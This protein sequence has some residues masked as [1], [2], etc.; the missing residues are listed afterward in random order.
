MQ[1]NHTQYVLPP[2]VYNREA[3]LAKKL[4]IQQIRTY[5]AIKGCT[6]T[7][8]ESFLQQH[9]PKEE[10]ILTKFTRVNCE[11]KHV[12]QVPLSQHF[13]DIKEHKH[14]T[15]P[16]LTSYLN[17]DTRLSF[18]SGL[19]L[20]RLAWRTDV[21]QLAFDAATK[22]DEIL[23]EY[24]DL[25]QVAIKTGNNSISGV[26]G[27]DS[28]PVGN[29][30]NHSTLTSTARVSTNTANVAV[31]RLFTGDL[32]LLHPDSALH[33]VL[34]LL[35]EYARNTQAIHNAISTGNLYCPTAEEVA[36]YFI[37]IS[38][39]Y[40]VSAS[41]ER[42]LKNLL[43][44]L[45]P[46]Q[47]AFIMYA[48]NLWN[49][50]VYNEHFIRSFILKLR[51][52]GDTLHPFTKDTAI[53]YIKKTHDAVITAA[54]HVLIEE[55]HG[56]G[57]NYY[58]MDESLV[59]HIASVCYNAHVVLAEY[60]AVIEPLIMC[61]TLPPNMAYTKQVLRSS[62]AG[63]DTD[64]NI[65][66]AKAFVKWYSGTEFPTVDNIKTMGVIAILKDVLIDNV[67]IQFSVNLGLANYDMN[68]IQ[69]KPE[70]TASAIA[71]VRL[72]KTYYGNVIIKERNV[73]A[74]PKLMIKGVHLKSSSLPKII[75]E[76]AHQMMTDIHK[77][78]AAGESFS[79]MDMLHRV[80]DIERNVIQSVMRG[81]RQYLRLLRINDSE[82]Y[83]DKS[84]LK[85]NSGWAEFWYP[86]VPL[87]A[88]FVKVPTTLT[89][90]TALAT[91]VESLDLATKER[92]S[93]WLTARGKKDL[94]TIYVPEDMV[95]AHGLPTFVQSAVDTHRIVGDV[96]NIFYIILSSLNYWKDKDKTVMDDLGLA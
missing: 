96:C 60:K 68:K 21:K 89:S 67:L 8:I 95:K 43:A 32:I 94:P 22:G 20:D 62:V 36:K 46:S 24:Q 23:A 12:E 4:G 45:S 49:I 77:C 93:A 65:V 44:K 82:S 1:D 29:K 14:I 86:T 71:M 87:P 37:T 34:S 27:I 3:V 69:M 19:I 13:A 59:V 38:T 41:A 6:P 48:G 52:S 40:H 72:T 16:T 88:A 61:T 73:L 75:T 17:K 58:K 47:L 18:H 66:S 79:L 81:D 42:R 90:K 9:L 26:Y 28:T 56:K 11:D 10:P 92:V 84:A 83:K 55:C 70:L 51:L 5:L 80:A 54:H 31:E 35:Q 25:L 50:A 85:N 33:Y 39:R 53:K 30:S 78:L 7:Q 63:S 76:T 2:E 64:S 91:W 57:N 74:K 15:A